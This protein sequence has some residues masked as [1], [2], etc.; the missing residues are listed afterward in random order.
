MKKRIFLLL[1]ILCCLLSTTLAEEKSQILDRA[2]LLNQEE[3]ANLQQR[4]QSFQK[5]V[6]MDFVLLT[7]DQIHEETA[8]EIADSTY[9]K[10]GYGL[11]DENSGVIYYID[12]AERYHYLSTAGRA[13][14][15]MTDKRI[16]CAISLS[17]TYLTDGEYAKAVECMINAIELYVR[18]GIPFIDYYSD[19][20]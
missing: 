10:G 13:I 19:I 6:Q 15:Y 2:N 4:I 9:E 8:T 18:E 17:S 12:M 14:S 16:E 11:G 5:N 3:I 1:I 20:E 7:S